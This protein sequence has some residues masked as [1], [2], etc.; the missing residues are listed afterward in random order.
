[1]YLY[2]GRVDIGGVSGYMWIL[3]LRL[4]VKLGW[5]P[6][7]TVYLGNLSDPLSVALRIRRLAPRP[8]DVGRLA[9]VVARALAA[10]R[11]VAER[12]RDSPRWRI[13]TWEALALIDEAT[14]AVANAWPPT[15]GVFWKRRRRRW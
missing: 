10:A 11:Y 4:Y 13:R 12:C 5:R 1:M 9:Y 3:G 6:R 2:I 7:D 14:S 8:V 15:A